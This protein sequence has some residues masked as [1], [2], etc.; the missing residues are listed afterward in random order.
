MKQET[1]VQGSRCCRVVSSEKS[2]ATR[3]SKELL[4]AKERVVTQWWDEVNARV[5][6]PGPACQKM[7]SDRP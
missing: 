4:H 6:W 5:W 2:L 7:R 3:E 1:L